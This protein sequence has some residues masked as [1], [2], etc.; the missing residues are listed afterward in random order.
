[1]KEELVA[2]CGMNCGVCSG[3]LAF[4]H[5]VKAQGIRMPYCKSCRPRDKKCTFLKKM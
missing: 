3:Y 5:D 1:M 4:G 2:P